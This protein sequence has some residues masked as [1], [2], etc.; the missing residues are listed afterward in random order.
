MLI[1]L[2]LECLRSFQSLDEVFM[3][4]EQ[5]IL[6]SD[7]NLGTLVDERGHDKKHLRNWQRLSEEPSNSVI[8]VLIKLNVVLL[9]ML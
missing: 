3:N 5:G 1:E 8:N 9:T 6:E 7:K 2:L 4:L